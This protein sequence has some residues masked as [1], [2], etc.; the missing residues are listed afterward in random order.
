M[1]NVLVTCAGKGQRFLDQKIKT[2]KPLI[3]ISHPNNH[4][5]EP[6]VKITTDSLP[7]IQKLAPQRIAFS[8]LQ[9]HIDEWFIDTR[10]MTIYNEP[11]IVPFDEVTRGNLE[12]A[13]QSVEYLIKNSGWSIDDP[14][15][16]LDSDNKYNG[17]QFMKFIDG[18]RRKEF[19]AICYFKPLDEKTHWCFAQMEGKRVYNLLEKKHNALELGAKPMVGVFYFSSARLFLKAAEEVFFSEEGPTDE[20]YYM[21]KVVQHLIS[22]DVWVY[23]CEVTDVDPLGTPADVN[24]Y[25]QNPIRIAIDLDDTILHCKAADEEYGNEKPQAR[26]IEILKRWKA[27]GHYIIIHTAR[28]ARTCDGNLGKIL[29]KQGLTTLQWLED[30]EV[31]YDEIWWS[32]PDADIFIDDKGFRHIPGDWQSTELAVLRFIEGGKI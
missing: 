8:V 12:T 3:V 16:I 1:I 11:V 15:L 5:S 26:A 18:R 23:G 29:A 4:L 7:F 6:M 20:E 24:K 13:Y 28:H 10:L 25:E 31:P 22:K 17:S 32:K 21:S 30:N 9:E 14:V 19:A 27:Q 2:P